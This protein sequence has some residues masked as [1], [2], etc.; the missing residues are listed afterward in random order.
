MDDHVPS[1][2]NEP[3]VVEQA[4]VNAH[5]IPPKSATVKKRAPKSSSSSKTVTTRASLPTASVSA[6][7]TRSK[8]AL[9]TSS[10]ADTPT[11]RR[12]R[13]VVPVS[14]APPAK[15]ARR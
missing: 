14:S 13:N 10:I 5:A 7:A 8:T 12:K 11:T 15:R 1:S 4:Q 9:N 2:P 6:Y 3:M